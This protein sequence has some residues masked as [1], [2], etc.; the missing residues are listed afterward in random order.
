MA[1][2]MVVMRGSQEYF[3]NMTENQ[4]KEVIKKH[5]EWSKMLNEKNI[6]ISG[7]G[8]SRNHA[9]LEM[10]NGTNYDSKSRYDNTENEYS[11]YYIIECDTLDD[12]I[13]ICKGCPALD[14]NEKLDI[15]Q[16]G[17]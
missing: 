14:Y 15:I 3:Y 1:H 13:D 17:H 8:F 9:H 2:F 11:G 7:N 4:Q 6:L 10:C 12:A 5:I 16:I